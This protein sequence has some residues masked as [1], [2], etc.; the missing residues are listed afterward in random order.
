MRFL[1]SCIAPAVLV[2]AI[3]PLF[4]QSAD[5]YPLELIKAGQKGYGKTVFKGTAVETFDVEVLGVLRNVGPKQNVILAR[6]SGERVA[7][8]GIFAGMSGSPVY[9]EDK[10]AGAVAYTWEFAK[11]PIVGI[12]PI[13]EMVEIFKER[14]E[15]KIK[16]SL[17]LDPKKVYQVAEFMP[18]PVLREF[19]FISSSRR[20]KI[21]GNLKPIA[22]PLSLSGFSPQGI[23]PFASQFRAMGLLPL[24]GIGSARLE[25]YTDRPLEAGSTISVQMVRGDMEMSV[26]GTVTHTSGNRIYAFGHPFLGMGYTD[27]PLNKAAVLTIIQSLRTSQK[28]S[29]TTELVGSIRQDRATGILG[30]AGEHPKLIPVRLRL[31]TSRHERKEFN[32]EI[33]TDSFLTPFLLTFTVQNSIVSSERTIGGQTLHLKCRISVRGQPEV[34]FQ[35][36]VSALIRTPTVAALAAASPVNFL[37]N[38]GFDNVV[39]ERI[40]LEI[41]A[42]EQ[43]R[44][45]ILEKVWQD[46][47][48]ARPGETLN[49]TLF[50]RKPNGETLA[51]K[52]P[53]KI[54]EAVASGDLSIIVADGSSLA[55]MD[56]EIGMGEFVPQ[57]LRQLIRAINNLKKNDR[58][59]I[60]LFRDEPGAIIGGEGLPNLP[61]SLLALY[62]SGKTSG[63][64]KSIKKAI[65]VEYELPA[66]DFV[67]SGKEVIQVNIEN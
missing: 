49:L 7:K 24:R 46:K 43:T 59:Y 66:T 41:R 34:S 20:V 2:G 39:V 36:S 10:M 21:T 6:L 14:P 51:E 50:L 57:N 58:L 52:Y 30:M 18:L 31:W 25:D 48:E 1:F 16:S 32:Y 9:I 8:T 35:N 37:L 33:V 67:L 61:P 62:E 23:E 29:A 56:D 15:I 11:E 17:P 45:A 55:Q 54:P 60:R 40:E 47:L 3:S 5:F 28:V 53:V 42:V 13:Y 4:S 27:M 38:S 63:N 22:T 26:S 12:T 64:V 19:P 65:Y 44:E